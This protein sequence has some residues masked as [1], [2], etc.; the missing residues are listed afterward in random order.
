MGDNFKETILQGYL[1]EEVNVSPLRVKENGLRFSRVYFHIVI[2]SKNL[3]ISQY[4][5]CAVLLGGEDAMEASAE[6]YRSHPVTLRPPDQGSV[7]RDGFGNGGIVNKL[8][9]GEDDWL[10]PSQGV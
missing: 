3:H 7:E 10:P 5:D 8:G 1:W 6:V 4:L 2:L 9:V